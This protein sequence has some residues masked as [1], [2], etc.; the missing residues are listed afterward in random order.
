MAQGDSPG[1]PRHNVEGKLPTTTEASSSTGLGFGFISFS[2]ARDAPNAKRQKPEL[3]ATGLT[4]D[5]EALE[6]VTGATKHAPSAEVNPT[7]LPTLEVPAAG[8]LT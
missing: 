1:G 5:S 4:V 8:G 7:A 6:T 3:G 2:Q